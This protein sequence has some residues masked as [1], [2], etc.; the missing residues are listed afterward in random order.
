MY[1]SVINVNNLS[2]SV[3]AISGAAKLVFGV[4]NGVSNGD[5]SIL[6]SHLIYS[7]PFSMMVISM[8]RRS[9]ARQLAGENILSALSVDDVML[10]HCVST[11]VL[12]DCV[13]Y[14]GYSVLY[15]LSLLTD[16]L[17]AV[18]TLL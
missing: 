18:L 12:N 8:M 4:N 7:T 13:Y 16:I 11:I 1:V 15:C 3:S 5:K 10:Y 9:G 6:H 14:S 17:S 2:A